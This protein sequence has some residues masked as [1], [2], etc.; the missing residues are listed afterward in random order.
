MGII[1]FFENWISSTTWSGKFEPEEDVQYTS[2]D[3]IYYGNHD[4]YLIRNGKRVKVK[5][6]FDT[7]ARSSSIDFEVAKQLGISD[8]II[9]K[10][11]E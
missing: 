4:I 1:K 5:A 11:K 10:C 9:S 2:K 7:G 6:K 3:K 8:E